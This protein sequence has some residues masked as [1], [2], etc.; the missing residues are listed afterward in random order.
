[1]SPER[2][3]NSTAGPS[4]GPSFTWPALLL[5]GGLLLRMYF[6]ERL[7]LNA[8]EAL[9]YLLGAQ[10]SF[11]A[12]FKASLTTAHPPL[13]ILFLYYWRCLGHSEFFLRLPMVL[14]GLAFCRITSRWIARAANREVA[15][16][17]L[18]LL[19]FAQPLVS[20]SAE[21]R[22]YSFLLLF[23]AGALYCFERAIA[24]ES[25][26]WMVGFSIALMLAVFS[27]YSS[28]LFA[29][30]IGVYGVV[31]LYP[32][33]R[34]RALVFA[35]A[36]GQVV[37]LGQLWLLFRI[38]IGPLRKT[39]LPQDIAD[40]WLRKSIFHPAEDRLIPFLARDT[41]RLFR[42]LSGNGVVGVITLLVFII[43]IILLF[44]GNDGP[45]RLNTV[46]RFLGTLLCLPFFITAGAGVAGVYPFGGSR[47]DVFLAPFAVAAI[48]IALSRWQPQHT[49]VRTGSVLVALAACQIF[50][51]PPG[52]FIRPGDQSRSRMQSAIEFLRNR[53]SD[54]V[55]FTDYQ[56]GLLLSYYL[57]DHPAVQLFPPYQPLSI[58]RCGHLEVIATGLQQSVFDANP[59]ARD[60][61]QDARLKGLNPPE[62]FVFLAG[63]NSEGNDDLRWLRSLGCELHLQFGKNISICRAKWQ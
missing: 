34:H 60:L 49:W 27:H 2:T 28:L 19:L 31:R 59:L 47:H 55:V 29:L 8:D 3:D 58:T 43:G 25:P 40:T 63:W 4:K 32:L 33:R 62:A 50:P 5:L 7:F 30:T 36:L 54:S 35:W 48:S 13:L 56:G 11:V 26:A 44:R 18:P 39:G 21:V 37:V 20:L 61:K 53:P 42:Y 38:H 15:E 51:S 22:Q 12:A 6:A 9:H 24:E 45:T 10:P 23:I 52:A 17:A 16:I 46:P 1:M 41:V 14:A 57:C